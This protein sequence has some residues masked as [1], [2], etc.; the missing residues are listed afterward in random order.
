[1]RR[2]IRA[3]AILAVMMAAG[4]SLPFA[5]AATPEEVY[6]TPRDAAIV[7]IKAAVDAEKRGPMDNYGAD[8]RAVEKQARAGLEKQ[9]R[10][11]V[12]PVAIKR[13][14]E[15]GVVKNYE[16]VCSEY[17]WCPTAHRRINSGIHLSEHRRGLIFRCG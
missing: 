17:V 5:R 12:G 14:E 4:L 6:I 11:I 9:M 8:I 13:M 10:T 1:M 2:L 7:K 16:F 15:N 3:I